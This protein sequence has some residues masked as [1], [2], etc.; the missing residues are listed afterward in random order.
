MG[1]LSVAVWIAVWATISVSIIL[2]NKYV[3]GYTAFVFPFTLALWHMLLASI[4][5]RAAM[6]ILS[7][8]DTIKEHS[9]S[10]L[11]MQLAATGMLFGASLVLG[12]WSFMY[13]SVPT[14]QMLK[15]SCEGG[16]PDAST[17]RLFRLHLLPHCSSW[18]YYA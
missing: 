12:F 15:V 17:T 10:K 3:L 5:S 14:I 11:E 7:I 13:L 8:P 4:S 1:R 9:S 18:C 6:L 2:T 16:Q